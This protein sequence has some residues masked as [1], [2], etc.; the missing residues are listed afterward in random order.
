MG[1]ICSKKESDSN[2]REPTEVIVKNS[3]EN[4]VKDKKTIENQ[5]IISKEF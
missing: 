5:V 2:P 1:N 3:T 4:K